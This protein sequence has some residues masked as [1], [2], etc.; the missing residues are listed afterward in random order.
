MVRVSSF[1]RWVTAITIALCACA[2]T[3]TGIVVFGDTPAVFNQSQKAS[4]VINISVMAV[5]AFVMAAL[6]ASYSYAKAEILRRPVLLMVTAVVT[7]DILLFAFDKTVVSTKGSA[8]KTAN[9][10]VQVDGEDL[11]MG[12][13]NALSPFGFR[14]PRQEPKA[15]GGKRILFLGNS[16]VVGSGTT[17]ATNYPQAF[18][19]DLNK[20]LPRQ[21]LTVFSAGVD[22]YG[23]VDDRLLYK[24]LTQQGYRFD[25]VVLNFM[26][27]SDPTNDIPGTTRAAIVGQPQRLHKNLFLRYFYP[28]NSSLFRFAVYLN[29]TFNQNWGTDDSPVAA[30]G[31][32]RQSPT[33]ATFSTERAAYYYGPG[34]QESINMKFNMEQI[35]A[36]NR[37]VLK[38]GANFVVVLLPDS[39]AL[40][41]SNRDRFHG[42]TM[43]WSWIRQYM[44][45]NSAGKYVLMDLSDSFQEK[46]DL[47]RCNDT[48]WNDNGNLVGASVFANY[49][50]ANL[51]KRYSTD[52]QLPISG[53]GN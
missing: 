8:I 9:Y 50:A 51:D 44:H 1:E 26:L 22:G 49:F 39:N 34:A 17:F 23:V 42:A 20:L 32:C 52:P 33:Y 41:A 46:A 28:L 48:H 45:E 30:G 40:V 16:Y 31:P 15:S 14:A 53:S 24:Y 38:N 29:I 6:V 5:L 18:E 3:A 12:Q 36:L 27:G 37:E 2:L 11:Y 25:T 35:D 19:A 13:P 7:L 47:F 4:F 21:G 10:N 43:D